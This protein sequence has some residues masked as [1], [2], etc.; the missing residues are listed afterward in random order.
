MN[1]TTPIDAVAPE[2]L[3]SCRDEI[4]LDPEDWP[5][6]KALAH[7]MVDDTMDYLASAA[8]RPTWQPI[9]D[10]VKRTFTHGVP[11][12][13][14]DPEDVYDEFRERVLPYPY[15]NVHPRFWGWVCG[16]GTPL[17]AMAEML[18]AG[19]NTNVCGFE[20]SAV[21]VEEQV[22]SWFRDLLGFPETASGILVTGGSMA[23]LLGLAVARH[24]RA[25]FDVRREGLQRPLGHAPLVVYASEQT[26]SSVQKAVELLGLGSD[27]LRLVPTYEDYSV[28]LGALRDAIH[29]DRRRGR[30]PI[31]VVGNAGTVNTGA[32]DDLEA[33]ARICRLEDVWLHVDGAFGALAALSPRLRPK[34]KGLELADS[35]AF[36]LHKWMYMPYDVGC[37]LVRR[38]DDHRAAFQ[39]VPAYLSPLPGGVAAGPLMY[40]DYGIELS[41]GFRA[42]KVWMSIKSHG[43]ERYV[44]LIEQNVAQARYLAERVERHLHLELMAPVALNVVCLRYR[45]SGPQGEPGV[46]ERMNELNRR[47]LVALQESG[48]AVPSLTVLKG[49]ACLRVA[50]TNHRTRRADLD[51]LVDETVRLGET[52]H[53]DLAEQS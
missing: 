52:L 34:L 19:M 51:L 31:C 1:E 32:L 21:Y 5:R 10:D 37:L 27:A 30:R 36:D 24:A 50:I 29:E 18:A 47:I 40:A 28:D 3:D 12:E 35:V 44:R 16:T 41:R 39:L 9:P 14:Q 2:L 23:N 45:L 49:Q 6:L 11:R 7:R 26:H 42:L 38:R 22:I 13:G 46:E 43:I 53:E 20:Q 33:L 48:V 25:G 4:S 15:G 17:G 8:E